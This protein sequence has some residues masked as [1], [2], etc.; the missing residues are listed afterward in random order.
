MRIC[1]VEP[2]VFKDRLLDGI[3]GLVCVGLKDFVQI[4]PRPKVERVFRLSVLSS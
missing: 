3:V 2:A 1:A 4:V